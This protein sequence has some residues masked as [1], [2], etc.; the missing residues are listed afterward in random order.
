MADAARDTRQQAGEQRRKG[1]RDPL[2]ESDTARRKRVRPHP[3]GAY[4]YSSRPPET[5]DDFLENEPALQPIDRQKS[6]EYT[7]Y[8]DKYDPRKQKLKTPQERKQQERMKKRDRLMRY[9]ARGEWRR[10]TKSKVELQKQAKALAEAK[11]MRARKV[12][13]LKRYIIYGVNMAFYTPQ[14]ILATI[15]GVALGFW[16]AGESFLITR[17]FLRIVEFVLDPALIFGGLFIFLIGVALLKLFV[18]GMT[19]KLFAKA[20]PLGGDR[21]AVKYALLLMSLILYSVPFGA[22]FPWSM[23]WTWYVCRHPK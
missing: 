15:S 16:A 5:G 8:Q 14:V 10:Y 3:G 18:V 22:L 13:W 21:T 12:P 2:V 9:S 1:R 7:N 11:R 4:R 6:A 20:K 23:I 19:L 17:I